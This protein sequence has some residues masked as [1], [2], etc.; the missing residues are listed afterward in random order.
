[1]VQVR[2]WDK[3][4]CVRKIPI[5]TYKTVYKKHTETVPVRVCRME[6]YEK[7]IET[8]QR[9]WQRIPVTRT[10]YVP[11]TVCCRIP[12]CPESLTPTVAIPEVEPDEVVPAPDGPPAPIEAPVEVPVDTPADEIDP[13]TSLQIELLPPAPT[14]NGVEPVPQRPSVYGEQTY[15]RTRPTLRL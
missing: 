1:M 9:V 10:Y 8:P 11:R 15:Q 12:L 5:S 4:Q 2:Y 14:P 13:D 6:R 3:K 7:T